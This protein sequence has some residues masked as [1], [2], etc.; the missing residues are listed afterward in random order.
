MSDLL[1][2][3]IKTLNDG[4]FQFCQTG[5]IHKVLEA[6]WMEHCNGFPT[7]TKFEAPLVTDANGSEAKRYLTNSYDYIIGMMLYLESNTKPDISF[8]VHQCAWFTHNIKASHETTVK[9][10]YRHLRGTKDNG[11]VFNPSKKLVLN[12][13]DDADLRGYGDMKI[14][15]TLFVVGVEMDLW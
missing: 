11:L 5:L 7:T 13:F 10:I 12:C 6:A 9:R 14:L 15:N 1:G 8:S 3:Y 2:I 4:G